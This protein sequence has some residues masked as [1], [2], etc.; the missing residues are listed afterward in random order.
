MARATAERFGW[1]LRVVPGADHFFT[2]RLDPF[3][4][5]SVAAIREVLR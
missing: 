4:E 5:A 3:E 1:P 2:G